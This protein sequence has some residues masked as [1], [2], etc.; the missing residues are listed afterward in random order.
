V[1]LGAVGSRRD[2]RIVRRIPIRAKLAAALSVPLM[3]LFMLSGLEVVNLTA[4]VDEIE[5]QTEIA[6]AAVGPGGLITHLQNERTFA[7]VKSVG[8]DESLGVRVPVQGYDE[9]RALTD[10]ALAMVREELA[11]RGPGVQAAYAPALDGL[12]ALDQ[13]RADITANTQVPEYDTE[14]NGE[15]Q[16][17]I[18]QRY[19][20]LIRP[21]FDATDK[22]ARAVDDEDLREGVVQVN[23][24][25]RNIELYLDLVRTLAVIGG[26]QG[27]VDTREEIRAIVSRKVLWDPIIS[28]ITQADAPYADPIHDVYPVDFI[29]S[30]ETLVKR[31]LTGEDVPIDQLAGPLTVPDWG[32]LAPYREAMSAKLTDVAHGIRADARRRE[33]LFLALAAVTLTAALVLT[34]LVSRSI[35]RP[36]RS[37]TSQAN[38]MARVRLPA[39]VR[40][41]LETPLGEDVAVPWVNP[42]AVRTRDEVRDVSEALNTVQDTA[43]ELAVEQAVLRRNMADS[44]VNLGR[45]NQNLLARQLD[46]ITHLENV[47]PSSDALAN[48]F[49]LDH[50]ATRMRRNAESL[51]VL[52]GVDPPR[53]WAQPVSVNDVVRAALGEV[54]DYQRVA[55]RGVRPA[56]VVGSV[57]TDLAHLLA[58]LIENA[59]VFSPEDRAVE[60]RGRP[61]PDGRYTLAIVDR[62]VGMSAEA[63]DAS[64]RRLAGQESFTVAPSKYLGHYV[65]G[66]LAARHGIA[67][68][69]DPSPGRGITAAVVLPAGLLHTG[70]PRF[71]VPTPAAGPLAPAWPDPA[72]VGAG[73]V[74]PGTDEFPA[75]RS[76]WWR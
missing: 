58:E 31:S 61:E 57:A 10:E 76:S 64:N 33:Q 13:L 21:F 24:A 67:V 46:L 34:W 18:Y 23:T 43:L 20:Q 53:Q 7:A 6:T 27:T 2:L 50:L 4:E 55:V 3:A 72:P 35:T 56:T 63:I 16:N 36:L 60:V 51:L 14:A 8:S 75:Y 37:L 15:F 9:T 25:S 1:V 26:R 11:Q 47:E 70:A 39:A 41:V 12:D 22:V 65:A 5:T 54:E 52:A 32:G 44:F 19:T 42:V 69:L 62:G 68:R 74:G 17:Q 66:N 40:E 28:T 30:I 38:A 73:A 59:L 29:E 45:R 49:R 71:A 48:L